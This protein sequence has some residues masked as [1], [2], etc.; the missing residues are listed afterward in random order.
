MAYRGSVYP[1]IC[2]QGGL[3]GA[4]AA[5]DIPS[6]MMLYGSRN[7]NLEKGGRRKRG[8]TAYVNADAFSG[9]PKI[10]GMCEFKLRAG[11]QF[12]VCHTNDG[13]IY[14]DAT[15]T[16]KTSWGTS[17][18]S[19]FAQGEDR[20]F[21]CD[22]TST[23]QVWTGTG[24]TADIHEAA[25]DWSTAPP[26]QFLLHGRL[27]S[28]RMWA[29]NK[30]TLYAS[31][32]WGGTSQDLEHFVTGGESIVIDTGDSYGLIGMQEY[33][34]RLMAFGK[35]KAYYIDD[36][37]P[38][39]SNWGFSPVQWEGGAA[40]FRLLI[41]TPNDLVAM[42]EDGEVYSV[43]AVEQ[44]GDY[45]AASLTKDS[46]MHDF[47]KTYVS[48]AYINDFHGV[49]DPYLRAVLIFV[50]LSGSTTPNAALVYFIDRAPKD[51]WMIHD[52]TV[53]ASGYSSS[54]SCLVR[55]A[56]GSYLIYTGSTVGRTWKLNQSTKSDQTNPYYN[57]FVTPS[58]P[59]KLNNIIKHYNAV[60]IITEA[61]G[62]HTIGLG[63]YVDGEK[64]KDDSITI[65]DSTATLGSFVL[66][67]D[68]LAGASISRLDS[69]LGV[70]G[71][72]IQYEIYNETAD[73]DFFISE[74]S[75]Q[76]KQMGVVQK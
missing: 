62:D 70:I 40:H 23:P 59:F 43:G 28:L 17:N 52:N 24:N 45:K 36:T 26:L 51:A 49:Y 18:Y 66:G 65:S 27:A 7:L 38:T 3:T 76:F 48:L 6:E 12:I 13:K 34:S 68:T 19:S 5:N 39:S 42:A 63:V 10:L 47:I 21:V 25:S 60:S 46:W 75:T 2:S 41:K 32:T 44:Y 67:T 64:V 9:A 16:I 31:K 53:Y 33:G 1:V 22:G 74:Y 11:T 37:D 54:A 15:N 61:S 4:T 30:T 71:E 20:L 8:G 56:A 14:K 29:I 50:A 72:R 35:R 57:G 58:D 69:R 55:T 73:E